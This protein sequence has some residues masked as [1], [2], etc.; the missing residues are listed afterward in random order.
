MLM[1]KIELKIKKYE[2]FEGKRFLI[3]MRAR[4]TL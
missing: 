2:I 3:K 4:C 1:I